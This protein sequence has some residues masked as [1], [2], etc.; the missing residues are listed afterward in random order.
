MRER[1]INGVFF[2][3]GWTLER[4][5]SGSWMLTNRFFD[6]VPRDVFNAIDETLRKDIHDSI[7]AGS[8]CRAVVG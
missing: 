7:L 2:D 6:Y 1:L 4:P 3:L 5:A 8:E